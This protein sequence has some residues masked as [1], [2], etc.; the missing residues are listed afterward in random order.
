MLPIRFRL[1]T[2]M[3]AIALLAMLMGLFVAQFRLVAQRGAEFV[4]V[5]ETAAII[6]LIVPLLL[7]F[8][9]LATYFLRWPTRRGEFSMTH[10]SPQK[11]R[12]EL[13]RESKRA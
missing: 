10:K 2:I 4:I 1:R 7:A 5:I 13:K 6:V 11:T 8:F 3:I 9:I 12:V